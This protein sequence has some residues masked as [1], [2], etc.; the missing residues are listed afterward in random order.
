MSNGVRTRGSYNTSQVD[1]LIGEIER[2][3]LRD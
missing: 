1:T 2:R 3:G